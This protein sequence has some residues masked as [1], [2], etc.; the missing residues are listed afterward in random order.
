MLIGNLI[1]KIKKPLI[2]V[3]ARG[4]FT[5]PPHSLITSRHL[6]CPLFI[7]NLKFKVRR[8]FRCALPS[9]RP[10]SIRLQSG[11]KKLRCSVFLT[12]VAR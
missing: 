12:P 8:I 1:S 2:A 3:C 9:H 7:A 5:R 4:V 6:Y 11:G 10:M